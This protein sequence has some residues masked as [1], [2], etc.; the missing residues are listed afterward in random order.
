MVL[1]CVCLCLRLQIQIWGQAVRSII[2]LST[3]R[4]CFQSMLPERSGL[5]CHWTERSEELNSIYSQ[6]SCICHR[7]WMRYRRMEVNGFSLILCHLE[8]EG[9]LLSDRGSLGRCSW[10]QEIKINIVCHRSGCRRQQPD[11]HSTNLQCQPA[12]EQP[13]RYSH[14]AVKGES[15]GFKDQPFCSYCGVILH[16]INLHEEK[17]SDLISHMFQGFSF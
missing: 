5:Q 14:T 11:I 1:V 4:N 8:G 17:K 15:W 9:P 10:P 2:A 13:Q 16:S 12:R 6:I 7:F 3:T